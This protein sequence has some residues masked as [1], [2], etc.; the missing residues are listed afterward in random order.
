MA[1][2]NTKQA[3]LT[4]PSGWLYL[5]QHESIP[6]LVDALLDWPPNR[7]FTVQEFADH[8]GV[9]RQTVR[10]YIDVLVDVELIETV[11]ETYPRRYRL[12]DSA[13]TRELFELNS[14]INTAGE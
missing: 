4:N 11:P 10:R 12:T 13:V 7:E 3:R 1:Q 9:V 2:S 5:T 6:L 8:A 14:A